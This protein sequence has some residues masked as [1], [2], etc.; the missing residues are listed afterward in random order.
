MSSVE[1][2]APNQQVVKSQKLWIWTAVGLIVSAALF[3]SGWLV[4]AG[5]VNVQTQG[6]VPTVTTTEG[7]PTEGLNEIYAQL[8]ASYDGEI[9]EQDALTALKEGL[10]ESAGDPFTEFFTPQ[11]ASDFDSSLEG[12]FE[13]IGAELSREGNFVIIVAPI[14]G[15]PAFRAGIQPRDII[16]EI[17]GESATDISVSEAVSR[18]RG[19]KGEQVVL[20]VIRDGEQLEVAIVRDTITIASVESRVE[21][22]IGIIELSRFGNDT[23]ALIVQE[24]Q[25]LKDQGVSSVILDMRGNPGGLLSAAVDVAAV[26]LPRGSTVLEEKRGDEVIETLRTNS[27]PILGDIPTVVLINE[28]SASASEIVAGALR[29][30]SGIQIVGQTSFGKGSVQRIFP[31]NSGG[32]LKVTVA[33][34][35]TPSGQNI[36]EEGITPDIEVELTAEDREAERDPQLDRALELLQ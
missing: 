34:W 6:L 2:N 13:G 9:T 36:D 35:F 23:S 30:I 5:R 4:G 21:G 3:S 7:V 29:D 16:V 31:L 17:D 18:I 32:S 10:A 15:T 20:T 8:L 33:R 25:S 12:Q 14:K 24:A 19:P 28:G 11:E 27:S 26:W 1:E 22:S